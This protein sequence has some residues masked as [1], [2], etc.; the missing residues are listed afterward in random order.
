M[1]TKIYDCAVSTGKYKDKN[2]NEKTRWE[3]IGAIWQDTD[4]NGN[5][6]SY[7]MMKRTFN[8][9]GLTA[10]EGSDAIRVSFFKP[11][12]PQEQ[13]QQTQQTQQRAS[14]TQND[15]NNMPDFGGNGYSNGN[16]SS[17]DFMRSPNEP[18]GY[19]ASVNDMPF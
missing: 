1:A 14:N 7:M 6:Y 3:N 12:Q 11:R 15:Y 19:G 10:R 8:P 16:F 18:D 17:D 4:N 2:G 9:A 13:A 5:S